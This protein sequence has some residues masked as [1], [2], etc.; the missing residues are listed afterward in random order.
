MRKWMIPMRT[1]W[2][3]RILQ[4]GRIYKDAEMSCPKNEGA[5]PQSSFNVAASIK[6]R[7]FDARE[8]WPAEYANHPSMW[9]HL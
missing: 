5:M 9:P 2:L 7:K 6:M 3:T 8:T 4:C 1:A